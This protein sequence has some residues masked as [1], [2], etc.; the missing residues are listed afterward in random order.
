MV[1]NLVEG[2]DAHTL[3]CSDR[4][5]LLLQVGYGRPEREGASAVC[6]Q[7]DIWCSNRHGT[8]QRAAPT[9]KDSRGHRAIRARVKVDHGR[10]KQV[11]LRSQR[12]RAG[13]EPEGEKKLHSHNTTRPKM[14]LCNR[15]GKLKKFGSRKNASSISSLLTNT[16]STH[17]RT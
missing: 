13:Q 4:Q 8:V 10:T 17:K 5:Q 6:E 1:Q 9:A 16:P 3:L 14:M 11:E 2:G 7:T 15:E 12:A